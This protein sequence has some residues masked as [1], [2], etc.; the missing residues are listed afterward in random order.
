MIATSLAEREATWLVGQDFSEWLNG[1]SVQAATHVT[2]ALDEG[3]SLESGQLRVPAASFSTWPELVA[4][5]LGLPPNCPLGMDLRLGGTL[6]KAGA[7]LTARWLQPGKTIAARDATVSG[8]WLDWQGKRFRL[9]APFF[10]IVEQVQAFNQIATNDID[11]Q[12]K[13]W[14]HIR[15]G[16]GEEASS[17]LTD[18]FLRGLR[19]VTASAFT[20][21]IGTDAEGNLQLNPSLLIEQPSEDGQRSLHVPALTAADEAIFR[22][23]LDQLREGASAFPVSQ[24]LYVVAEEGL[25]KAL[26]AVRQ[27]RKAPIERRKQAALHPEA[28][29][30]ELLG[31]PEDS[32]SL[33][34]ETERFADRVVDVAEWVAPVLPWIKIPPQDWAPPSQ[35]GVRIHGIDVPL[36]REQLGDAC[37]SMAAALESGQKSMELGG[38]QVPVTKDNLQALVALRDKVEAKLAGKPIDPSGSEASHGPKVLVIES[39][40][41]EVAFSRVAEQK[42]PGVVC[43][44]AG[45]KTSAKPHQEVGVA[46][47]QRHWTSGSSG[48]LLCDDMGLGKTF[49]ALAFCAWLRGLMDEGQIP[50]QPILLVAPVG[51][52]RNWEKEHDEHL[53]SPGLGDIV[54]VYGEHV[55]HLRRGSHADGTASLDATR[56]SQADVVLANYEAISDYQLSFGAI[57][58]AAVVLDEAQ[59]I[60]SPGTRVTSAVKALNVGFFVAMTGTPVENRLADL[61]CIADAVQPSA[62]GDLKTFSAKYEAEGANVQ[63]LREQVWQDEVDVSSTPK[64]LLRRLKSEKLPGLPQKVEHPIQRPMSPRQL[65]VYQNAIGEQQMVGAGAM[66]ELIHAMRRASLHPVLVDGG[67]ARGEVLDPDDSAR[68]AVM[69]EVLDEVSAK[70]EKALVFLES[71]DLQDAAQLP[72]ILQRR[73]GLKRLPMIINGEVDAGDRQDRVDLF[74]REPGF[75]VM[76]LSPKAGGV[77]LTLT[78]ANHVIHLSRWWNPAVEDQCSDRVYRIGQTKDVHIYYPMAV[79]PDASEHSFDVQLQILMERKRDLARNL[80]APPAFNK[81]DYEQLMAGIKRR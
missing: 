16:L 79:L 12:F 53:W 67:L 39:N 65:N 17:S 71:L 58:F 8:A 36:D 81:Q 5:E 68:M 3:A 59:K 31:E 50:R 10:E 46:W 35:F 26:T 13:A 23:R 27:L 77:G 41:E 20:W 28:V 42:R 30:R 72:T 54:R 49:Q 45:V 40:F 34:I 33:F 19:V 64:L 73:Y 57:P 63:A 29:I 22:N 55:K 43:W 11:A 80:L 6:G 32:T 15:R 4:T 69:L 18:G 25:R 78:A 74:Q 21:G 44:P 75:D 9:Q 47:L 38:T 51:L 76:L 56:M 66:L 14:A 70:G 61:W 37:A 48:A 2:R 24:G 1:L 60:K 52:L 62:L 7:E